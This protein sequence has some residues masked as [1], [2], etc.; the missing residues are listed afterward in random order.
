MTVRA[1]VLA[2]RAVTAAEQFPH[3]STSSQEFA[4]R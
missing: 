2:F 4:R 3:A 1:Q